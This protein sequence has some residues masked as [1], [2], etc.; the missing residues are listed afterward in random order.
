[1]SEKFE[2]KM[3]NII[4]HGFPDTEHKL[5][6]DTLSVTYTQEQ[7]NMSNEQ[8]FIEIS[9]HDGGGGTYLTIKTER[10]AFDDIDEFISLLNDFKKRM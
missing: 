9:T 1:V 8:Q 4:P 6:V 7:D 10:W 2:S 5:V 3:A